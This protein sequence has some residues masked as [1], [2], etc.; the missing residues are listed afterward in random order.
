MKTKFLKGKNNRLF[1]E[2]QI[3]AQ[4]GQW[5]QSYKQTK[6]IVQNLY[7]SGIQPTAWT[8]AS[9]KTLQPII[10]YCFVQNNQLM[11]TN[12]IKLSDIQTFLDQMLTSINYLSKGQGPYFD[13]LQWSEETM[14]FGEFKPIIN[15]LTGLLTAKREIKMAMVDYAYGMLL[16]GIN[17]PQVC[18]PV[19]ID[20]EDD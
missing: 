15:D 3:Q 12:D 9:K 1:Y 20:N 5:S 11:K 8:N 13:V 6:K 7:H 19:E 4:G 2:A 16:N 18:I 17:G 10:V 14:G